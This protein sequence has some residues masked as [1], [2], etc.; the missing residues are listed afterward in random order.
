VVKVVTHRV[1]DSNDVYAESILANNREHFAKSITLK[2]GTQGFRKTIVNA[3]AKTSTMETFARKRVADGHY[4]ITLNMLGVWVYRPGHEKKRYATKGKRFGELLFNIYVELGLH[5]RPLFIIGRRKVDRGLGFHWAPRDG[6]DG[7]VWTDMILGRVDDK[8]MAVQKAGRLAGVVAQCPQYP[9]KLTWWTDEKT[10]K[11]VSYHNNVVDEANTRRGCSALQAMTRAEAAV[12]EER[13]SNDD[14]NFEVE[15]NEFT[16]F[17]EAKAYAP[18][19]RYPKKVD[20]AGFLLSATTGKVA[21]LSYNEVS[22]FRTYKKTAGF[23]VSSKLQ[24]G[25]STHTMYVC[26]RDLEDTSSVLF[27]VGKLT[28]TA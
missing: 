16:T 11:S 22:V 4:A 5:D 17:E 7:L 8:D 12:P 20:N 24:V 9:G 18:R 3:G 15:W 10:S 13:E 28:K 27:V 14:D 6:S 26:Y 2:N 25:K 23:C 21:R 1:K 19:V